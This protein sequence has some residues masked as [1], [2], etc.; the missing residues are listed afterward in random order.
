MYT[1]HL[2]IE[3]NSV[4]QTL[5]LEPIDGKIKK[6]KLSFGQWGR[7]AFSIKIKSL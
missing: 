5:T 3:V 1:D 2:D 6:V 4:N 7:H